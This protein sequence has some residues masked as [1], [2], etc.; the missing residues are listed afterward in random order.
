MQRKRETIP[1]SS[2]WFM[3]G[4]LIASCTSNV[5]GNGVDPPQNPP[6]GAG[7]VCGDMCGENDPSPAQDP[8]EFASVGTDSFGGFFEPVEIEVW[9]DRVAMCTAVRGLAIYR[10]ED[11]CC[12]SLEGTLRPQ[13][14]RQYPR[15]QHFSFSGDRVF[16]SNRGDEIS[17][18]PFITSIDVTDLG[19]AA[20]LDNYTGDGETSFEGIVHH[21][22]VLYV[23]QHEKGLLVLRVSESGSL[24]AVNTITRSLE[25][26]WQPKLGPAGEYL[27]VADAQGGLAVFDI[28]DPLNPSF[29]AKAQTQG[30]L[31]DLAIVDGYIYGASGTAGLEVYDA[32]D[33]S[34]I[35]LV[36]TIDTDGSA[37]GVAANSAHVVLTDWN[38][39]KLFRRTDPAAPTLVGHQAAYNDRTRAPNKLGRILDVALDGNKL[40]MAEWEGVQAH[41][42]TPDAQAPDL[43]AETTVE[44]P[45][46]PPGATESTS[47]A[48]RNIGERPLNVTSVQLASTAAQTPSQGF[49]VELEPT[50]IEPGKRALVSVSFAPTSP[51]RAEDEIIIRSDDPDQPELRVDLQANLPGLRAGDP[52][53]DIRFVDL[54]GFDHR[55]SEFRGQPVLLAYFATF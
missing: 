20:T 31:K 49:S 9:G 53:L 32:R 40:Y 39:V 48:I 17:P 51:D 3:L 11:P 52:V 1:P 34:Q 14:S 29:V 10:A 12:L 36:H 30:T 50:V 37:L 19:S 46:T 47:L 43:I 25:N 21:G 27:Y 38:D 4:A 13:L 54:D 8:V 23:A 26:A 16:V 18:D 55:L 2:L 6:P 42:I 24:E 44:L 45:R 22:N 35:A 7:G 5:S 33:P 41:I 15:C 28:R